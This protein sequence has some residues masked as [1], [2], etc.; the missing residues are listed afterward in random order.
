MDTP[1]TLAAALLKAAGLALP[2]ATAVVTKGALNVKQE[3]RRSSAISSGKTAA[4]APKTINFDVELK[5]PFAVE[6]DIGYDKTGQ[7]NFGAILEYGSGQARNP[8]HRDLGRALDAEEQRF[9]IALAAAC[10]KL[11]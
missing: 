3:G 1:D 9:P 10:E 6:A 5:P 11:L 7:G 2:T 8:P 4:G